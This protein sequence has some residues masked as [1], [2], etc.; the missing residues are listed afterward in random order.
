MWLSTHKFTQIFEQ[1]IQIQRA[2]HEVFAFF[3]EPG[4][5]LLALWVNKGNYYWTIDISH[6]FPLKVSQSDIEVTLQKVSLWAPVFNART[7]PPALILPN[8]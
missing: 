2:G 3:Y 6:G 4:I 7:L 1:I 5:F 8:S